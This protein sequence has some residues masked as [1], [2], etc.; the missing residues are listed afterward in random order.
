MRQGALMKV[1]PLHEHWPSAVCAQGL[2]ELEES[3]E[4]GDTWVHVY[5]GTMCN[6]AE[7]LAQCGLSWTRRRIDPSDKHSQRLARR[8]SLEPPCI[9]MHRPLQAEALHFAAW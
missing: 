1:P 7:L 3:F 9:W 8:V 5:E 2:A 6:L 4:L